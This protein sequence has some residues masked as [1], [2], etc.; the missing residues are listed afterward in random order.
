MCGLSNEM[1]LDSINSSLIKMAHTVGFFLLTVQHLESVNTR[2][3]EDCRVL[4]NLINQHGG[5]FAYFMVVF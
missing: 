1:E 2:S 4:Q 5:L 3:P